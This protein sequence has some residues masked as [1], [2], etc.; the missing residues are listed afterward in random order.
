MSLF[1][2][3]NEEEQTSFRDRYRN[4]DL[5][6]HWSPILCQL[7]R[8]GGRDAISLWACAEQ[9][10]YR[11]RQV[12]L[13]RETEIDYILKQLLQETDLT[14]AV[15]V[16]CVVL[17]HL[18]NAVEKGHEDE[19]FDNEPMCVAIISIMEN[20]PYKTAYEAITNVFFE[21]KTGFDGK[22]VVIQPS[23][24]MSEALMFE[25]LANEDKEHQN[26][27]KQF[28]TD[29][30]DMQMSEDYK[31]TNTN[32]QNYNNCIVINGPVTNSTLMMPAAAPSSKKTG[33]K[34]S[35]GHS[36]ANA[37]PKPELQHGAEYPVFSKGAGVTDDHIKAIY[38]QL[39]ARGWISTQ[40]NVADFR[41][42]FSGESNDCEIIWTGQDKLGDNEPTTLGISA[43][44]VLFKDMY[45]E[46]LITTSSKTQKVGPILESHFVDAEGHF[47]TNVSNVKTTSAKAKE[48]INKI[49]KM[50]RTRP[51]SEDIQRFLEE[52]MD[53]RYDRNDRQDLNYRRRH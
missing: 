34:K 53:S 19:P 38:R 16:M 3:L 44:Y 8:S 12:P 22:P 33:S 14:T 31:S 5:F 2:T 51:S 52:D 37:A 32:S 20:P 13:Y 50:M 35:R 11:L 27:M 1:R 17:I 41:R 10:L 26:K 39:T 15:T 40:T 43:L 18:M 48:M 4:N 45:D 36:A 47:L 28:D 6:R 25:D 49:L 23:D 21:R 24:P 42:L 9:C 30:D 29:T 46:G 7:E